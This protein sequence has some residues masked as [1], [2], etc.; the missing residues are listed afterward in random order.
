MNSVTEIVFI[1]GVL[2]AVGSIV[3]SYQLG[4][5]RGRQRRRIRDRMFGHRGGV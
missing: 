2:V 3:L 5:A 1:I 4:L